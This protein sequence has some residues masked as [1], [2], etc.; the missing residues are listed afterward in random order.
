MG[1]LDPRM[2]AHGY[3]VE[4]FTVDAGGTSP[5]PGCALEQG[6]LPPRLE[7]RWLASGSA[8]DMWAEASYKESQG[9]CHAVSKGWVPGRLSAPF[10]LPGLLLYVLM[11]MRVM[12]MKA[13]EPMDNGH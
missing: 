9:H 1:E 11:L 2:R 10:C 4:S 7:E 12:R 3:G 6:S 5:A 8:G 13:T